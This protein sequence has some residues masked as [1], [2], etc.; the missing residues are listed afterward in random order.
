M[1]T[2]SDNRYHPTSVFA[3]L[4]ECLLINVMPVVVAVD[5]RGVNLGGGTGGHVPPEF[6]VGERQC[7]MSP[8]ILTF[9][10]YFS[11]T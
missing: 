5:S 9:S 10:L 1:P 11:L 3:E 7:I 6:G 8:Q 4:I 2:R